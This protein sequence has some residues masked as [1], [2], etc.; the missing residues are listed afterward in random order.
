MERVHWSGPI[1]TVGFRFTSADLE[2]MP[3]FEGVRYE[4]IDGELFVSR[5]PGEPH[6]YVAGMFHFALQ[7]WSMETGAGFALQVP[8]LVFSEDNEVIPDVV[9]ISHQRRALALDEKA[10][11][12]Y[13]PEV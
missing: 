12:R 13:A 5:A 7:G 4:I 11:Y 2:R 6:Q 3:D 10:H 9:W 1:V 8:G